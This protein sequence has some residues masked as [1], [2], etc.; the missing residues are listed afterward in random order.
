VSRAARWQE[1]NARPQQARQSRRFKSP[2]R[3]ADNSVEKRIK[4]NDIGVVIRYV[5]PRF[6]GDNAATYYNGDEMDDV[7][8]HTHARP[9]YDGP[10]YYCPYCRHAQY[11]RKNRHNDQEPDNYFPFHRF[12]SS[13]HPQPELQTALLDAPQFPLDYQTAGNL[14]SGYM[15]IGTQ[16][17]HRPD[18]QYV[19]EEGTM[20]TSAEQEVEG[21]VPIATEEEQE[22]NGKTIDAKGEEMRSV[23]VLGGYGGS[24]GKIGEDTELNMEE[25]FTDCGDSADDKVSAEMNKPN[26][27]PAVPLRPVLTNVE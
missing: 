24:E 1:E 11:V 22:R 3:H 17:E 2:K 20:I 10:Q 9:T 7:V 19:S 5:Q 6:N 13:S 25:E 8:P 16:T 4:E 12:A 14:P 26:D 21:F 23:E 18:L 15:Y 27:I